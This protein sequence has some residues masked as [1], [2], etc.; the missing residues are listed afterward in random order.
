MRAADRGRLTE[1]ELVEQILKIMEYPADAKT[2]PV[3]IL[4]AI[5]RP[6]WA[7][8]REELLKSE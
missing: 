8:A 2:L 7:K 3:G 5:S 6:V 4:T 1:A